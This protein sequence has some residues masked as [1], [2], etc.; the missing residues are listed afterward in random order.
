MRSPLRLAAVAASIT[1]VAAGCGGG[2]GEAETQAPATVTVV[3][4]ETVAQ[5]E[6]VAPGP[7]EH[8]ADA[9]DLVV[10]YVPVTTPELQFY[11]DYLAS[12]GLL[13]QLAD[14]INSS[15]ALPR[16]VIVSVEETGSPSPFYLP[17]ASAIVVPP[18]W[19]AFAD[20][21]VTGSELVGTPEEVEALVV[22]S[23]IFVF[24]HELGHALVDQ[25]DLPV[26]GKEEDAVDQ[27]ATAILAEAGTELA[28]QVAL[29]GALFFGLVAANREEFAAADFWDEHSLN[30]QRFYNIICWVYGSD[31]ALFADEAAQ[32]G[33]GEDRLVRCQDEYAQ[34][35]GAWET[36]LGP[37]LTA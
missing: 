15:I 14:G 12:S 18:E 8:V 2:S 3:E 35:M 1:L 4:T 7:S 29:S 9:G 19:L 11:A 5:T 32:A 30:E 22:A 17:A 24:L 37:Y 6:T 26:T 23:T 31:P 34:V 21:L 20:Q 25:L 28:G 36:L 16:D 33:L 10:Q 13:Q 27:L